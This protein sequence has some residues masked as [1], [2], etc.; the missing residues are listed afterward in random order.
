MGLW[1]EDY[2]LCEYSSHVMKF[3]IAVTHPGL[4]FSRET[5]QRGRA[6]VHFASVQ[7]LQD[8]MGPVDCKARRCHSVPTILLSRP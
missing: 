5:L 8:F 3:L 2:D 7:G 4:L 6:A 1:M